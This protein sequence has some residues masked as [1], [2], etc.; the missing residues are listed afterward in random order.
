M[1]QIRLNVLLDVYVI[2]QMCSYTFIHYVICTV[3]K[4][5]ILCHIP[6]FQVVHKLGGYNRVTNQNQWKTIS[7]KLGF[8]QGSSSI[9]NLV[10]QAY[11]K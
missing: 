11:K 10:K 5:L 6:H 7:H 4:F 9:V 1:I 2:W 3:L 8:G